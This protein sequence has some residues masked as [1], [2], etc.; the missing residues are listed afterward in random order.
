M[1]PFSRYTISK[2]SYLIS[3]TADGRGSWIP[4]R[5][6]QYTSKELVQ[7]QRPVDDEKDSPHPEARIPHITSLEFSSDRRK[8]SDIL[9]KKPDRSAGLVRILQPADNT[10]RSKKFN[11]PVK[12]VWNCQLADDISVDKSQNFIRLTRLV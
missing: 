9:I 12:L 6:A 11:H 1:K 2:E 10:Q 3:S 7:N 5:E 8:T 4:N